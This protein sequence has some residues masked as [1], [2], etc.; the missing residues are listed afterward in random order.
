MAMGVGMQSARCGNHSALARQCRMCVAAGVHVV[1]G[2]FPRRDGPCAPN[3]RA[4][5]A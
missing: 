4:Y 1:C 5:L 2:F 3:A